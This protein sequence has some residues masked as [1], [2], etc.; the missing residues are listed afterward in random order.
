MFILKQRFAMAAFFAITSL[1]S[2]AQS[3]DILQKAEKLFEQE[4]YYHSLPLFEELIY[5]GEDR[6]NSHLKAGMCLLFLSKPE[7]GLEYIKKA[8][9]SQNEVNPNYQFWLGR[10]YHLNMKIDSALICYRKYLAVSKTS[11]EFRRGVEDLIAQIHRTE[12]HFL[13]GEKSH[14][15]IKNA[16]ENINSLYTE[17]S[18]VLSSNG[19]ILVFTSRRP[20]FA[21]EVSEADGQY[22]G[23]LFYSLKDESGKWNKA[24]PLHPRSGNKAQFSSVQFL[25][26]S[27]KLLLYSPEHN[28]TLWET[29]WDEK[30]FKSPVMVKTEIPNRY[31]STNGNFNPAMDRIAFA[32]NSLFDGTY[33]LQLTE[34]KTEAK[35]GKPW[36]LDKTINS[37][38]DEIAP[39]WLADGKTLVFASRGLKGLGG[40]DLFKTK[41]DPE[42]KTFSEPEN[43]GYPINTPGNDTH[44]F[45]SVKQI[46]ISSARANGLGG[47]DIYI[48]SPADD[49]FTKKSNS[50]DW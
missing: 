18:P 27:D 6:E 20:L 13:S 28:G 30:E 36:K 21:D 33:D 24:L 14:Y 1:S 22:S 42:T 38:E 29:E 7:K 3:G 31:F 8:R 46:F 26:N 5:K 49:T 16:G 48:L 9:S 11:D 44:Y 35:W 34:R 4:D 41:Y 19:K 10:A 15:E 40:F 47:N 50:E 45:E 25:G 39:V 32:A 17:H 12:I 23:K 2:V 37:P 43:L